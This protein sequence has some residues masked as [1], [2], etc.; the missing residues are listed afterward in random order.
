MNQVKTTPN[1]FVVDTPYQMLNAMEAVHSLRLKNNHLF[2]MG[3][4]GLSQDR[5]LPLIKAEDWVSVRFLPVGIDPNPWVSKVL[6]ALANRCYCLY[7]NFKRMRTFSKLTSRFRHVDK[8]FLGHYWA[9]EKW[10]MRHFAN[11]FKYNT[12]YLLDDGTDTI[13]INKRRN[14]TQNAEQQ[15][16]IAKGDAKAPAFKRFVN[17]LRAKYW[18]SDV[19][20]APS[21]TFFTIYKIDVRNGDSV[22]RNDYNYL[23]SLAP[24][25]QVH[26]SDTVIFIGQCMI[27]DGSVEADVYLGFLSRVKTYFADKKLIYVPHPRESST[28]IGLIKEHLQ[29]DF[30]RGSSVIEYDLVVRGVKPKA[31]ASFV[32][33]ALISLEYLVDPD[34][35]IVSFHISSENWKSWREYAIG[36]YDYLKEKARPRITVVSLSD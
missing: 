30:W 26:Q 34:V 12:L 4:K 9:K 14:G 19:T 7:L 35:E 29:C 10:Y 15:A 1:V 21:V 16:H 17:S 23:R 27:D 31:V 5:Y 8:L 22:I 11:L 25:Q 3:P 33:S 32:S 18:T 2:V 36:V 28:S 24:Q 6:G 13:N 20:E